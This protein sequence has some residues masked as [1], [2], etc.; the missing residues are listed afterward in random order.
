MDGYRPI[1]VNLLM[2]IDKSTLVRL[3]RRKNLDGMYIIFHN[4]QGNRYLGHPSNFFPPPGRIRVD[5]LSCDGKPTEIRVRNDWIDEKSLDGQ[6]R[7]KMEEKY[8][9]IQPY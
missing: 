9:P 2:H 1:A 7:K 6:R 4:K 5:L 3:D 8:L